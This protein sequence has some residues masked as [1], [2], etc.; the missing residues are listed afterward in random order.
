[1]NIKILSLI[2]I[3]VLLSPSISNIYGNSFSFDKQF[4]INENQINDID[5]VLIID[6]YKVSFSENIFVNDKKNNLSDSNT[7]TIVLD[8]VNKSKQFRVILNESVKIFSDEDFD[9][10]II[11]KN[12]SERKI[13]MEK[14]TDKIRIT[15]H[16][17]ENQFTKILDDNFFSVNSFFCI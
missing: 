14:L 13:I 3:A 6:N 16:Q 4:Q 17:F 10:L 2:L 1:L 7:S 9:E 15:K 11:I 12:N 5:Q 8:T